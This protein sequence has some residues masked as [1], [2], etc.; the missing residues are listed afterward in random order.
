MVSSPFEHRATEV[1][2]FVLFDLCKGK[3]PDL[4]SHKVQIKKKPQA[5]EPGVR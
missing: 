3:R 5:G 2:R 1:S 4:Q